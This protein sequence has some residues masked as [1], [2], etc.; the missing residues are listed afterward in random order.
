[1]ASVSLQ[2]VSKHYGGAPAVRDLSFDIAEGEF[3]VIL[4]ASG[5]GKTTTLRMIAGFVA[6]STGRIMIGDEDVTRVPPRRRNIGMVFQN[7][8]LFPN[9]S[10]A[11]NIAFGLK[12]RRASA[13]AIARRVA[14]LLDLVRLPGR[15]DDPVDALSGGQQQRV[16]L[17]RALA[18][19]PR[20]LLMDEP[21]S[22]LDLKLREAMRD[23]IARIQRELRITTL[24]VTHDQHEAMSLSDRII[25]MGQGDVQQIGP[26]SE[27]YARPETPFVAEFIGKNNLLRAR[28]TGEADGVA[29]AR[30]ANGATVRVRTMRPLAAGGAID[31]LV[32]PEAMWLEADAP[33]GVNCFRGVV[34]RHRFL[35]NVTHVF[36][37][38]PWGQVLLVELP[39]HAGAAQPGENVTVAW[40]EDNAIAFPVQPA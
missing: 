24:F 33:S 8:A 4:G 20:L 9:M 27:L 35:G 26:P 32:R 16:A 1:M 19:S 11:R 38:A 29:Q 7:Y 25:L 2:G 37:R 5:C 21:L 18:A 14:E 13:P 34:E 15:G 6:P 23:E 17:A 36:V 12:Q 22:A 10:V 31:I 30:L 3:V 40:R 39:G 28:V